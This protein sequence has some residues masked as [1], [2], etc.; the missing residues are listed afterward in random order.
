MCFLVADL[1][2]LLILFTTEL[3][4]FPYHLMNLEQMKRLP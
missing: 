3:L 4:Q 2:K 1:R